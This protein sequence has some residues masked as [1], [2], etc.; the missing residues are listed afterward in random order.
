MEIQLNKF[1]ILLCLFISMSVNAQKNS[2][3]ISRPPDDELPNPNGDF[4]R[5]EKRRTY[6]SKWQIKELKE[7]AIIVRLPTNKLAIDKFRAIGNEE[8]AERKE[9]ETIALNKLYYRALS[10]YFKFC[11][12]Y[13]M[14]SSSTDSLLKGTRQ[15]LFLDSN[16]VRN[17]SIKLDV[18]YYLFADK[19][20][21]YNSSIGLVPEAQALQV[22]EAGTPTKQCFVVFK[23][24][25]GHQLKHPF[26]YFIL[27]NSFFKGTGLDADYIFTITKNG[28]NI[29][30]L[31][32]KL[33]RQERLN[34]MSAVISRRLTEFYE[35]NKS[36]ELKDKDLEKFLY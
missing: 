12:V 9:N 35:D 28:K 17:D 36:F 8:A 31:L 19:D 6:V 26:P 32:N 29:N 11:K 4:K 5:F 16:L 1:L 18:A 34:K 13:F 10:N 24:K 21:V 2:D 30:V 15:G 22:K 27:F 20:V 7:G 23:N 3:N 25:Y 14:Y 33:Y